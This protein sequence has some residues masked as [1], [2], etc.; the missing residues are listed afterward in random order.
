MKNSVMLDCASDVALTGIFID[1]KLEM[2]KGL[3]AYMRVGFFTET[4][5]PYFLW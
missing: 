4:M 3:V 5:S 2:I 1:L